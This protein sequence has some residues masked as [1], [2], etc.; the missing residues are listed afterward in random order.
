[1]AYL[2][3]TN[4]LLRRQQ[5]DYPHLQAALNSV[6]R[7]R[8]QGQILHVARQNLTEFR[9]T[10]SRPSDKN[11]LGPSPESSDNE[12]T[13][14]EQEFDILSDNDRIYAVWRE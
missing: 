4:I 3:D 6:V 9:N 1:M 2:T 12:L 8:Q 10:A 5:P 14:L 13:A 7:L 11:G